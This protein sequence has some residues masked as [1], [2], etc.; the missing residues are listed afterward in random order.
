[1][2]SE[3]K[4]NTS[5]WLAL[6]NP[7]FVGLWLPSVVSGVCVAAHDT[8]ATWLMNALGASALLLSLIATAASL[9]F[10]LF[11]LPAGALADLSN[12]R[13]LLVAVYLW[14]A[15]AAGLLAVCTWLHWVHPYVILIT[16]FLLGIGFAFN[17]PVW[18]SIIPEMVQKEELA[19]AITL[20]GV[21]MN[22]A[23]IAGPALGGLLLPIMGPAMLFSL[24]AL[25]FLTTAWV[26]SQRYQRRRRP[27]PHLEN[28]LE[29]F[30]S[31]ARYVRYAPGMQ[32]IL[33][34][35]FLFGLF[36]AVVP[37][38]VPVV[39]LQHL[40]LQASQ[41]GL[42]FTSMGIGSLLGA[43]LMLPYARAKASPNALTI[44]AGVILVAVLVLMAIVPNLWMFLPV[45]ALAGISWTVSA[46]ELWI[47]GQR[48]MPDWARGR[49]N[50]VHMMASQAGVA[51]GGIL[52]GGAA[53]SVGLGPTLVGG[54]LLLTASLAL[55][56]PLSINFAN[57]L[58]LDPAP[59]E[60]AHEFSLTPRPED[61]PVTVTRELI[62]RHEDREEFLALVEQLRLTFLRNG[63][64]LFR[65]DEN[66]EH[67]GTFRTEML[68]SSWAEHLRQ[69]A[70]MTKTEAELVERVRAMHAGEQEP[71][72]RHYLPAK[73]LSTPLGFSRF[74]KQPDA[75][76]SQASRADTDSEQAQKR[77]EAA[78]VET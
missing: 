11:T 19:S 38:L 40:R 36:I 28:F 59:L 44:L 9:P 4:Q 65:I 21:Q 20:G 17:A 72:V 53:T 43:T 12:R 74:Q 49:M 70:R 41:L 57:S 27:E 48:T 6:R 52:W 18:A 47:A 8:A 32:V 37:A 39:A 71:A 25:A 29:S 77:P 51:L 35:D 3:P 22:L 45:T 16:V 46:S 68:V 26:I 64:F 67:P 42:V 23:G 73:R 31:A 58:N 75:R 33:T 56:V 50:A 10:F 24:N 66:L 15:A 63:A 60:A 54:A 76:F 7:A 5:I 34:R 62:I 55:A 2:A 13:N 1:M 30:A 61:G 14:L 69:V 78:K